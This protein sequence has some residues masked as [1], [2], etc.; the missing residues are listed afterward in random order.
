MVLS[1]FVGLGGQRLP[2]GASR[3]HL[4]LSG[5]SQLVGRLHPLLGLGIQWMNGGSMRWSIFWDFGEWTTWA[6]SKVVI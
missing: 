3:F 2:P 4:S 1:S 5:S 6:S